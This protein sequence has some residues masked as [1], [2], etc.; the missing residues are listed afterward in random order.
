MHYGDVLDALRRIAAGSTADVEENQSLDFKVIGRSLGD[1]LEKLARAAVCFANASGGKLVVGVKDNVAGLAAFV[2]TRLD[3]TRTVSRIY[4]L[5][6]PALIVIVEHVD[7]EGVTLSVITVPQSPEIHQVGGVATERVGASCQPMNAQRISSVQQDRRGIDWSA[8][9]S[10]QPVADVSP[11]AVEIARDMLRQ[12][13]DAERR[14]W[15][16]LPWADLARRLGVVVDGSLTNA[17]QLLFHDGGQSHV[18]Y[19]RRVPTGGLLGANDQVAG[20]GLWAIRRTIE[21]IEGRVE[22][23]AIV[24]PGGQQLLVGD[25]PEGAVREAVIN[26]FMH[27]DYRQAAPIQVEHASGRLR[28]TSPGGF[29]PGVTI[30]NVL[31]VSSRSRNQSLVQA[32]RSLGLGESAG[33]GVDRMYAAMAAVGHQPPLFESDGERVEI[34]LRGGAPNEPVARF[35]ADLQDE[36][37]SSPDVLLV[38]MHLLAN[39]TT[40]AQRMAPVMQKPQWE[41]EEVLMALSAPGRPMLERTAET[42]RSQWG[43]YR[44]VGG[45]V[46]ELGPAVQYRTRSGDDTDRK[47]VDIVRE[48]ELIT[49]RMVQ[50]MFDVKPAT[51]SRILSDLVDRGILIKTSKAQ[52]GPSVTYGPGPSFP[53]K[54]GKKAPPR[55]GDTEQSVFDL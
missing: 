46:R 8:K 20:S 24:L 34:V 6:D 17:G 37:R 32:L 13:Q 18:H 12:A 27:R 26:A 52:R 33:V 14:G 45:A 21:I 7:Y 54:R 55:V 22:R 38:M 23:T 44:L 4:E 42:A 25:V 53:A 29:V 43:E 10:E 9:S 39:R 11:I 49:G 19:T 30:D 48:A 5:T 51:A 2:D 40:T 41:A 31:T 36:R 35:V 1:S 50:T 15:S 28:I 3:P 47:V 16:E